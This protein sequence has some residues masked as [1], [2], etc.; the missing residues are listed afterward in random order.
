MT[1][2]PT[3]PGVYYRREQIRAA[4]SPLRSDVAGFIGRT[5]WGVPGRAIRVEGW[6]DFIEQFGPLDAVAPLSY[7]LFGYFENGGEVAYVVRI[8]GEQ[9]DIATGCWSAASAK[10]DDRFDPNSLP[11]PSYQNL[12]ESDFEF[13]IE[14]KSP[15]AWANNLR[16]G[17]RYTFDRNPREPSLHFRVQVRGEPAERFTIPIRNLSDPDCNAVNQALEL[18]VES[19]SRFI[20]L[21]TNQAKSFRLL[22]RNLGPRHVDWDDVVLKASRETDAGAEHYLA[23]LSELG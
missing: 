4:A 1:G 3:L 9:S 8:V 16:V 6:R 13:C 20:R 22:A 2:N 5:R 12:K 15:G 14:A 7:S 19:R 17:I 21:K 23:A 11:L 18:D 10:A